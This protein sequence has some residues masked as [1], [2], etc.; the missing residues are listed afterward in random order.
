M[1]TA[2]FLTQLSCFFFLPV[3]F[4]EPFSDLSFNH[5]IIKYVTEKKTFWIVINNKLNGK[6]KNIYKKDNQRFSA[7]KKIKMNNNP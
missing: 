1:K 7:L 3:C 5:T 4:N 6:F 2:Y